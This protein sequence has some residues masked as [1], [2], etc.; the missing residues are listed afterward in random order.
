MLS[1]TLPIRAVGEIQ[2]TY[3]VD[4]EGMNYPQNQNELLQSI[5]DGNCE[6]MKQLLDSG[7]N[8][9]TVLHSNVRREHATV[10]GT[11]A[12][13]GQAGIIKCLVERK[14]MINYQDPCLS[15]NALHWA[16]IGG[17]LEAAQ[18]LVNFG[19]DI[20][21]KDRD[22]VTP[23]IRAAIYG[24]KDIVELLVTHGADVS[25][26]DRLHSSALHYASFHGK[27]E[28]VTLLIQAGCIQNNPAI[29]GQGTP[30]ANLVYHGDIKNCK[31][32]VD[33]GYDL[34]KD[35]WILQYDFSRQLDK[36]NSMQYPKIH[37]QH[38]CSILKY[39]FLKH[40]VRG[41]PL[42]ASTA[43]YLIT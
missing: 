17:K 39:L 11:A 5:E 14:V 35:T 25:L 38:M 37:V 15:R 1:D 43:G 8:L 42:Q 21:C 18:L 24:S 31:R 23:I 26:Y 40:F 3:P 9:N 13:E 27:S 29:F 19:I 32:L 30:L 7:I 22:N 6:R 12:L 2:I 28:V 16:A 41:E 34:S 33:V 10:L 20:N 4:A 36:Y